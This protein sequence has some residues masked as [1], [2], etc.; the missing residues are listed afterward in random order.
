MNRTW[1]EFTGSSLDE[2]NAHGWSRF[3]HPDELAEVER[4]W[5]A[6]AAGG[7]T[8][9]M[10]LRYRR[11]DGVYRW[12]L[13]RVVPV[14]DETGRVTRWVGSSVDIE[15]LKRM[16]ADRRAADERLRQAERLEAVGRLAGGVAHDL[17]NMLVAIL[18]YSEFVATGLAPGDERRSDVEAIA[19][20]AGRAAA[21]TRQLLAFA[22]RDLVDPRLFD[23]NA[24][25]RGTERMLRLSVGEGIEVEFALA[26]GELMT[27]ADPTRIEQVLLNLVLNA[28]DAM[29]SGG[30]LRIETGRTSIDAASRARPAD[31]ALRPGAYVCLTVADSGHGM[32]HAT[33]AQVFEPFFTTKPFGQGTGLGLS[34]AYGSVKQAG[35][36]ITARSE[37]GQG[38]AFTVYL[39]ESRAGDDVRT[40]EREGAAGG[41]GRTILVVDD[42]EP[43]RITTARALEQGGYRCVVASSGAEA[44]E[45]LASGRHRVD[46]VLTDVVMPGIGGRALAERL[47]DPAPRGAGALRFR[48]HGRGDPAAGAARRRAALPRQAVHAAGTGGEGRRGIGARGCA[49]SVGK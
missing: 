24:L 10:E 19:D 28:R 3:N 6:A 39:P 25:V 29:P 40:A 36:H 13:A 45:I 22:R 16:E 31:S 42:A 2:L 30:R 5:S 43:V 32:D 8:F 15:E 41:A 27:W 35:G 26:D 20:A 38:A 46:L 11:R 1:K 9:E 49:R 48:I 7:T 47:R 34:S 23:L 4:R 21:L 37:P 17:N 44:L 18:G 33:L 12:M 14:K